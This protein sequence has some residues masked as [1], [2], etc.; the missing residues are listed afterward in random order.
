M[1]APDRLLICDPRPR[2]RATDDR[3]APRL[4]GLDGVSFA[5]VHNGKTHG[6][7]LMHL[8]LDELGARWRLGPVV[9]VGPPSPGYGGD[10]D[11]A[12]PAA[13]AVMAALSAVGD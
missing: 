4:D 1:T 3:A 10:P 12:K 8:I 13:E 6:M 7:E 9:E 11:D 2:P 5:L